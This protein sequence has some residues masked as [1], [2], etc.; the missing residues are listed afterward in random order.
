M[1][2]KVFYFKLNIPFCKIKI[3]AIKKKILYIGKARDMKIIAAPN[4]SK[5][6]PKARDSREKAINFT[7]K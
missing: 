7:S 1:L 2:F 3:A 6:F 5:K 4:K